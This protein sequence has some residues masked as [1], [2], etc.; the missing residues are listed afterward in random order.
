MPI[1]SRARDGQRAHADRGAQSQSRV[2]VGFKLDRSSALES[3]CC[4]ARRQSGQFSGAN[5][6]TVLGTVPREPA[7]TRPTAV[8]CQFCTLP[9]Y[10]KISYEILYNS[11]QCK[12]TNLWFHLHRH[13]AIAEVYL[14]RAHCFF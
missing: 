7:R 1:L 3:N 2:A 6:I 14:W 12:C 9:N 11:L 10:E 4:H 13:R 8:L 5:N